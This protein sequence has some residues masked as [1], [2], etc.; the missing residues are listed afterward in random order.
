MSMTL[1][2]IR[3]A[4]VAAGLPGAD[5][6]RD[7][8]F[9]WEVSVPG[10][11]LMIEP[12]GLAW[13]DGE[14]TM[15]EALAILR[16]KADAERDRRAEQL[17][18]VDRVLGREPEPLPFGGGCDCDADAAEA[19]AGQMEAERDYWRNEAAELRREVQRLRSAS[20]RAP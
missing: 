15:S 14:R 10:G 1:E 16:T 4:C 19:R 11:F 8:V 20:G 2:G 9:G 3:A 5:V 18:E 12:D 13:Q 17:A 7:G 6:R